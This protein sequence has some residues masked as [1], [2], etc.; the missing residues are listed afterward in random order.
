MRMKTEEQPSSTNEDEKYNL[1]QRARTKAVQPSSTN[2]D[3]N[4]QKSASDDENNQKSMN[5]DEK[6][7]TSTNERTNY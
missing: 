1:R 7:Q 4:K 3:E 6:K 2:E 5:K